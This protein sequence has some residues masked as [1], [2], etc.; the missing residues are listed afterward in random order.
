M[1]VRSFTKKK[2]GCPRIIHQCFKS[3]LVESR[4]R[5]VTLYTKEISKRAAPP[6]SHRK[7]G[8]NTSVI[9]SHPALLLSPQLVTHMRV[10]YNCPLE[11][12]GGQSV[13]SL[14]RLAGRPD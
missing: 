14:D 3:K 12:R 7:L 4:E 11:L 1:A 2:N 6:H 9:I 8:L 13:R 10:D 5:T